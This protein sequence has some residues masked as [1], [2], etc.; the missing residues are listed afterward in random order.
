[1]SYSLSGE[2]S[3]VPALLHAL[4]RSILA[5]LARRRTARKQRMVLSA[6]LEMDPAR[7]DDLGICHLD[8]AEAIRTPQRQPGELLARRRSSRAQAWV[9]QG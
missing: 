6:L 4:L 2:R 8:V 3:A 5:S 7:L 9:R 1:M